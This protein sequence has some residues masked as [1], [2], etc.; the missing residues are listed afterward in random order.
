MQILDNEKLLDDILEKFESKKEESSTKKVRSFLKKHGDT[1]GLPPSELDDM[2]VLL[3]AVFT[4]VES[5]RDAAESEK[6]GF[7]VLLKKILEKVAEKLEASPI[8]YDLQYSHLK[9]E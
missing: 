6:Y 7:A 5:Q 8:L 3:D 9:E 2:V 1:F 4:E